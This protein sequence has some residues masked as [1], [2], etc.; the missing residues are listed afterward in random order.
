M[1]S[2][3]TCLL[4]EDKE[5]DKEGEGEGEGEGEREETRTRS[6]L[7][8]GDFF[9]HLNTL[10]EGQVAHHHIVKHGLEKDK[11][12]CGILIRMYNGLGAFDHALAL[13]NCVTHDHLQ[14]W[15]SFI[16][17][18]VS[19]GMHME[20]FQMFAQM[21]EQS[22]FAN[23]FTFIQIV[24][25]CGR[26]GFV[27]QGKRIHV[28]IFNTEYEMDVALATS[29]ICMYGKCERFKEANWFRRVAAITHIKLNQAEIS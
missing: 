16:H 8:R 20:S 11:F 25:L 4:E 13:F 17:V 7:L 15:N 21:H 22:L 6:A 5:D 12:L 10:L 29:L 14:I 24:S 19:R 2:L 9:H 27:D 1:S 3:T 23:K 26:Y 18:Y 28:C